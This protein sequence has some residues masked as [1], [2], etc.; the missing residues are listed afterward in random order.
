MSAKSNRRGRQ[1]RMGKRQSA[2]ARG[3][4]RG[5]S[6]SQIATFVDDNGVRVPVPTFVTIVGNKEIRLQIPRTPSAAEFA[7]MASRRREE[8]AQGVC[9]FF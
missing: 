9:G 7:T 3:R 6:N 5:T 8:A 1:K 4:A 2:R